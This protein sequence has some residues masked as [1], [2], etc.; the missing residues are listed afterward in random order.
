MDQ[1]QRVLALL[2]LGAQTV[3]FETERWTLRRIRLLIL[4]EFGVD[5]H[6]HDLA[7]RL[8]ALGW[9]PQP[10]AVDARE[11]DDAVVKA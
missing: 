8:R 10:P 2:T 7:R 5:H 1:W 3:D 4:V 9:S 11:R 6:A